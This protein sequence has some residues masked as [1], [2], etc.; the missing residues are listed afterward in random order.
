MIAGLPVKGGFQ[1]TVVKSAI[2]VIPDL[3]I[4]NP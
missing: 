4:R 3:L 2:I 1:D